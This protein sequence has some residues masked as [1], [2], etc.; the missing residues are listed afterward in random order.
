MNGTCPRLP[1]WLDTYAGPPLPYHTLRT[2]TNQQGPS[3]V[4]HTS[5]VAVV[6]IH[7]SC[8]KA[9]KHPQALDHSTP[10][11]QA[12]VI[13]EMKCPPCDT[14][15]PSL[16]SHNCC[17]PHGTE[18]RDSAMSWLPS[19][20]VAL[21]GTALLL[22]FVIATRVQSFVRTRH[23]PGPFWAGWT[24]LWMIR[25]QL[26][27]RFCF[28]LQDANTRYGP[29]AK[30]AP[31]WVVCG[32]AEEL[33]RIWGVR[34][35][36]KRPFWYRAFRFDP[37]K[38]NAFS[39]TDDQVHEKL[40]AKLMPGYGGKDVD[41]LHELIDR[42]VAG[43]VSLL[44]TKYLSSKT[45]FKP[46]DLA[47]KVQY[48]TLD[49]ISALA[50]GKELGYLAADQDLF[51]YIQ[52][53]ESTLPIML[54]IGFMP[55]LLKLIQSPRLKF[56]MPDID[57]VV[58]IG[59]VVKTAQQAVAERYGDKPLIKR[60]MLGSFV[61]NGLTRE[62]AEGET[63]VQIIAGSDT[64]ATAIRSTLL[65][66]ITNPLVYRRLQAE[67]DTGIREGRISSPITDTEARNLPYLQA[68]IREGLR[69][70]P[71]A[72]AALPKVS[73]R[74]QVVCGVHIPAGTIIAW[75]PFSFLRSKKIFGEDAD[76]FRPER[77]LDIEPEKYRT[78][79]QTVMMEFAS[80]SRWECLGKT[81]AQIELNKA[82]VELLRRFDVTLVDPTNPWTSFNAAVFIQSDMNVVVT[83]REL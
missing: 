42:Q 43:L 51:S 60:D 4:Q 32:D 74:D 54:T 40:R 21:I 25:A 17:F 20:T 34:S 55:W 58:G 22:C 77:W 46:V 1:V 61:A 18:M 68:V 56:L 39:T 44:E 52:T 7:P 24:D 80:G 83:R 6:H 23:I 38:D 12:V 69:M 31:N 29:I 59:T 27:G 13:V 48:F 67:I 66:I 50:F 79:D 57:R 14:T 35:A 9:N 72:T 33:R 19:S 49:V 26:S 78:M 81:V 73:D 62:E 15:E 53:T 71:P 76:V 16:C 75:A 82:Y 64:S 3:V 2:P 37:Y 10:Q 70:W 30:I 65:F 41:N 63:V 36:W 28:L 45:E 8:C 5:A 47:R 11:K